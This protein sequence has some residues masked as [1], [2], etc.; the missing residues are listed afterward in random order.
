MLPMVTVPTELVAATELLDGA[1]DDL[2]A[3]GV[4]CRRPPLGMMVEVPAAAIE[5]ELFARADFFSI[6]SNDLTQYVTASSRDSSSVAALCDPGH[7]AVLSLIAR[8]VEAG[9][10]LGRPV[11]L[12]G[13]MGSDL[14]HIPAL[15][16]AGL[17]I[18][19]VAPALVGRTK[20][21]VAT[22]RVRQ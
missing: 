5:P 21:A 15:L 18:L 17:R 4:A 6:G 1:I 22:V 9:K 2:S 13:D 10:K 20:L 11:S 7:P 8:V 19:S 14:V 12:C 16:A 3:S